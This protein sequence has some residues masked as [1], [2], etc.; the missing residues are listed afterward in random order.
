MGGGTKYYNANGTSAQNWNIRDNGTLYAHWNTS[1]LLY[2]DADGVTKYVNTYTE[3]TNSTTTLNAGWYVVKGTNVQT[4]TLVCQGDVHLIISDGAKLTATGNSGDAGIRVSAYNA[5]LTIYGQPNQTGQLLATGGYNGA[6][7]GGQDDFICEPITINGG[8]VTCKG[9][10]YAAGI[11]GGHSRKGHN[12]TINGGVV[13]ATGGE[14]GA[15]I[16]GGEAGNGEYITINGGRV[17][18][19]GGHYGAAIGGGSHDPK[20]HSFPKAGGIGHRININGGDVIADGGVCAAGIGG[21]T[22]GQG[23]NVTITGGHVT[24]NGGSDGAGIGGGYLRSGYGITITGGDVIANG[25][26]YGAGIGSGLFDSFNLDVVSIAGFTIEIEGGHVTATGG[27]GAAGIGGG[28]QA[29][30]HDILIKNGVV[31]AVGGYQGAGIGGGSTSSVEYYWKAGGEARGIR[32]DGGDVTAI[33]GE[34]A[35]GIGGGHRCP[36]MEG[37]GGIGTYIY[38]N[39]GKVTASGGAEAAAIGGGRNGDCR[40]IYFYG[41]NITAN[42]GENASAI[43]AGLN[44]TASEINATET[45]IFKADNNPTPTTEIDVNHEDDLSSTLNGQRYAT[46]A[47]PTVT[48]NYA[49]DMDAYYSTFFH[50]RAS[51]TIPN[52]DVTIYTATIEDVQGETCLVLHKIEGNVIP[53]YTPVILRAETSTTINLYHGNREGINVPANSLNGANVPMVAPAN[54]HI[55]SYGQNGLGFYKY[56]AGNTLAAHKAY[57]IYSA[58]AGA[59]GLRMV[60]DDGEVNGI[61]DVYDDSSTGSEQAQPIYNLSGIRLNKLQKGINIVNGKKVFIK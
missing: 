29:N 56:A 52:E 12:I 31:I 27:Y 18:A 61:A 4:G 38:I 36:G 28:H 43:G 44:G 9:G 39:G 5:S 13:S 40:N 32:I 45:L 14:H 30:G 23:M 22:Y 55:L 3:I 24:A 54:C 60:F 58:P 46:L 25:G 59:K 49:P 35:A 41:G 17:S 34:G 48:L 53:N 21:G 19:T 16:G 47:L 8:I 57:L 11:G 6:G 2:V 26:L 15:G 37:D 1:R 20:D 7:I 50:R 51:Y 10:D 33:G 42:G